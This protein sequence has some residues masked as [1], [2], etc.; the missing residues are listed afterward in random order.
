MP[1]KPKDKAMQLQSVYYGDCVKHLEQ[2]YAHNFELLPSARSLADLI[3]L[4]PPWNSNADY[5]IL[6]DKGAHADEGFTAQ[7]T[8]FT[9]IRE[10]DDDSA[11][12]VQMLKE[13]GNL[14]HTG[15][16]KYPL[17]KVSIVM[18]SL[19]NI[20]PETGSLAYLAYMAERLAF[21][22]ELLKDTGSIYLHC[23]PTMSHYLKLIMDAVFG[24]ENFR[25]EIT[26]KRTVRGF[27]GS[28]FLPRKFNNNTDSILFYAKS[29]GEACFR[30]DRV[31]EPYTQ[32]YLDNA[33]KLDDSKGK[34]YLD[35]AF[36]RRGAWARPNLC[37]KYKPVGQETEFFPPH[38]SGWKVGKK[39]MEELEKS[40]E[41]VVQNGKL[42][43]KIRP[44][45]GKIRNNLWDDVPEAKGKERRFQTQKPRA[46]LRRIIQAS[47]NPGDVV[48]D[49]FCGCGTTMVEAH[50]L[51][52][53]FVGIDIS[54]YTVQNI[55]RTWLT[56]V[57]L[58]REQIHIAGIPQDMAQVRQLAEDD[59]FS[60]N[61]SSFLTILLLLNVRDMVYCSQ[62]IWAQA[63]ISRCAAVKPSLS[64]LYQTSDSLLIFANGYRF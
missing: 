63:G 14:L 41:L 18:E 51:G 47:T 61:T 11:E 62:P 1:S 35:V 21:C 56:E 29:K 4:D 17:K 39:R 32:E 53:R 64:N 19:E 25:N 2:W 27:K 49:P 6:W 57:G 12:R 42:Y 38:P 46:L 16:P 36:N 40:G 52:R 55:V 28:Q 50:S 60:L 24:V 5:N 7:A 13:A 30:M 8:A 31:L 43:R 22:R 9:D 26:W 44:K 23:D 37:Y 15:H 3:Y 34:Y 33:F 58:T 59:K 48:L 20:I 10:W 45:A 54:L